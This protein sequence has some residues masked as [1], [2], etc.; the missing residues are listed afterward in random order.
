LNLPFDRPWKVKRKVFSAESLATR[1]VRGRFVGRRTKG[2]FVL[3][4]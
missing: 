3:G 1:T 2:W 4:G